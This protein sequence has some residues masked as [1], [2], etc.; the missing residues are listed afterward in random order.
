MQIENQ[1]KKEDTRGRTGRLSIIRTDARIERSQRIAYHLIIFVMLPT[2]AGHAALLGI[3]EGIYA[4]L[5]ERQL[6]PKDE[7]DAGQLQQARRP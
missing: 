6:H 5:V 1:G 7:P 2:L 3:S 4:Q